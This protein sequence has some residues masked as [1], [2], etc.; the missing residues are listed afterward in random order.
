MLKIRPNGD[1]IV[2][3]L[4][5]DLSV[6]GLKDLK[7]IK[8]PNLYGTS[9]EVWES[10][11]LATIFGTGEVLEP[12]GVTTFTA[13][14]GHNYYD[15]YTG[16]ITAGADNVVTITNTGESAVTVYVVD[17]TTLF[18]TEPNETQMDNMTK[19]FLFNGTGSELITLESVWYVDY[20]AQVIHNLTT[21]YGAGQEPALE[22]HETLIPQYTNTVLKAK[23]FSENLQQEYMQM[24][25][26]TAIYEGLS[27]RDIFETNNLVTNGDF[28]N[29]ATGW[30][31]FG[32]GSYDFANERFNVYD[33]DS[34]RTGIRQYILNV[35][36]KYYFTFDLT[37]YNGRARIDNFSTN[38]V[39]DSTYN[40]FNSFIDT[41]LFEY[42]N[43]FSYQYDDDVAFKVDNIYII[44]MSLFTTPPSQSQ[45]DE[46]LDMY[47]TL[48]GSTSNTG[49]EFYQDR[50]YVDYD[51]A[52]VYDYNII[53]PYVPEP[54]AD[55]EAYMAQLVAKT[56]TLTAIPI[57]A[58][59][60]KDRFVILGSY[61]IIGE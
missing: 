3:E 51:N 11:D 42:F 6:N 34:V 17:L 12:E 54:P 47:L 61:V 38:L 27:L 46:W 37:V 23:S 45:L 56:I 57:K 25:L 30:N 9:F 44:N 59:I 28:S 36:I 26:D 32:T 39:M 43:I 29:G 15:T 52:K 50:Y 33:S 16:T 10:Q 18:T 41:S 60:Y 2:D 31:I 1:M 49:T 20:V 4:I 13:L 58:K 48:K 7:V 55:K 24:S 35:G 21:I 5:E 53:E 40:G 22:T 8:C 19:M 14:S